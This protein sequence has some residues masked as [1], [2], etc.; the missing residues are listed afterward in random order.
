MS[1]KFGSDGSYKIQSDGNLIGALGEEFTELE[2]GKEN[3]IATGISGFGVEQYFIKKCIE[4]KLLPKNTNPYSLSKE[5][6]EI[7]SNKIKLLLNNIKFGEKGFPD[8][9]VAGTRIFIEV[10]TGKKMKFQDSQKKCFA[11][12][13]NNACAVYIVNPTIEIS[14]RKFEVKNFDCFLYYHSTKLELQPS[15]LCNL[16]QSIETDRELL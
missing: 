11:E 5:Q 6:K 10:K 8:Y 2:F 16:N 7:V 1:H 3:L 15:T 13:I 9:W 12:L 4:Q 14:K